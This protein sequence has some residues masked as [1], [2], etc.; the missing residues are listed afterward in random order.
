METEITRVRG[1]LNYNQ[2]AKVK[3]IFK[4]FD[5]SQNNAL[6]RSEFKRL[7]LRFDIFLPN[8]ELKLLVK[9]MDVNQS[10]EIEFSE[11]VDWFPTI[12][13][14][15]RSEQ[16]C[17]P[18]TKHVE[19]KPS[20]GVN[21]TQIDDI[22]M[23]NK[24]SKRANWSEIRAKLPFGKYDEIEAKKRSELFDRI[25]NGNGY[26]S[27]AEIDKGL[28]DEIRL[29]EI[30]NIKPVIMRAF[31]SA[32]DVHKGHQTRSGQSIGPNYVERSEFRL[33]LK[34]LYGYFQLW[35]LFETTDIDGDRRID[36]N[37]FMLNGKMFRS[38]GFLKANEDL[39][40]IFDQLD[41]NGGGYILF[42]ELAEWA[43]RKRLL[44]DD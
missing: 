3:K 37:E 41:A 44:T 33:L 1:R 17:P 7:L 22:L 15:K 24:H 27:L 29:P 10:G 18:T 30:Y 14:L 6:D 38:W 11:L 20:T 25:D 34:Y 9:Q 26:L 31:Q 13:A 12:L 35:E 42:D 32:K 28:R 19:E 39:E 16:F 5:T 43:L 21:S 8:R 36:R 23:S 40:Q 4:E 2:V